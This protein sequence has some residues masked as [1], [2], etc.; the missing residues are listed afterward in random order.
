MIQAIEIQDYQSHEET[1]L[2]LSPGVTVLV[3]SSDSGKTAVM[4]ALN[5]A[6][7]NRPRGKS[8]MRNGGTESCSV[9]ITRVDGGTVERFRDR[10]GGGNG[11][12]ANG[13]D[14]E[15]IGTDVPENVRELI[16][17]API[18]IS[19][20][21]DSHFLILETPGKIA[22]ALSRAVQLDQAEAAANK[23]A[24]GIRSE[25]RRTETLQQEIGDRRAALERFAP[26]DTYRVGIETAV[27]LRQ[28]YAT[29]TASLTAVQILLDD[30]VAVDAKLEVAVPE[31]AD[32][33]LVRAETA[34][35]EWLE[36]DR[37]AEAVHDILTPLADIADEKARL[38]PDVIREIETTVNEINELRQTL[39][40]I[41][42]EA[43]ELNNLLVGVQH[44][45]EGSGDLA[46]DIAVAEKTRDALMEKMEDCP[47]CEQDLTPKAKDAVLR[48]TP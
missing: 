6:I 18:N 45:A 16:P 47:L 30:I 35:R 41:S 38:N 10:K 8:F 11:Y 43:R 2:E 40:P 17:L 29:E 9:K 39:L 12:R 21:L 4:R 13:E 46:V 1:R 44:E 42:R 20:Q 22:S 7:N 37:Q 23:L 28:S 33:L 14:L 25:T 27:A 26:L 5:W 48:N 3:G 34:H 36:L 32:E 19:A 24:S 31:D 15:A